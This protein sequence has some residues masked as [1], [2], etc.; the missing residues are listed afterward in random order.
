MRGY[1]SIRHKCKATYLRMKQRKVSRRQK[2][3]FERWRGKQMTKT[4]AEM[5][6]DNML[7]RVRHFQFPLV[8]QLC[9]NRIDAIRMGYMPFPT[10]LGEPWV[11]INIKINHEHRAII[12]QHQQE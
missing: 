8:K 9:V 10:P 1:Y 4:M 2:A 5:T 3:A 6:F 12:G 7:Q 11:L